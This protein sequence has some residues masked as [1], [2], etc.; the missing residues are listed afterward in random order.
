MHERIGRYLWVCGQQRDAIEQLGLAVAV[1][2]EDAPVA[3]RARVLGAEGHLLTLLGR[4]GEA[5]TRC[6]QALELARE[7]GARLEECRISTSLGA[8][9]A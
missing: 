5:R 2:P 7:G 6:E 3:D 4:G 8:G 1:M 9:A